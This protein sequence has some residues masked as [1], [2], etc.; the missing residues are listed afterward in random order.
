MSIIKQRLS[1]THLDKDNERF[2]LSAL[3]GMIE[4]LN[5]SLIPLNIEHDPRIPPIG[6]VIGA[7]ITK[8]DDN[9]YALDGIVELF[10]Q[11]EQIK[12]ITDRE[13][14][15][16]EYDESRLTVVYD[17][18]F[19]DADS[20]YL[21]DEL[22]QAIDALKQE[23]IKKSLEPVAVIIIGLTFILTQTA[24]GFFNKL[25]EDIYEKLKTGL[26]KL[27]S[28]GKRKKTRKKKN[29]KGKGKKKKGDK[30]LIFEASYKKGKKQF[31]TKLIIPNPTQEDIDF[32][33]DK[34][35]DDFEKFIPYLEKLSEDSITLTIFELSNEGWVPKYGLRK[36]GVPVEISWK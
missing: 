32:V 28:K 2:A 24:A 31:N 9:E 7:E 22:S 36:D 14:P 33:M 4:E 34:G 5:H 17:R 27:F 30:L 26:K 35:F 8:L 3:E 19:R 13:I 12:E 10:D 6:R 20:L 18:G 25:G 23:E 21:I 29:R 11:G 16:R 1:T 15:L